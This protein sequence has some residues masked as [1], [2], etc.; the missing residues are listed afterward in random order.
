MVRIIGARR[1]TE[2]LRNMR[3]RVVDQAGTAIFVGS[4]ILETE[5]RRLIIA[6]AIQG[7]GHIPSAPGE[8]P[9]RDTG[10]LDQSV[11]AR[12]RGR[13]RSEVSANAPYALFLEFG[14]SRM[15]ERPFMRP[16]TR[17]TRRQITTLVQRA[18]R[19][20]LAR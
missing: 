11:I 13:V 14:T 17:R 9:N 19:G 2:R 5:A 1:H 6:N 7:K 10:Q 20:A 3:R 4:G 8:P 18:V 15:A 12:R 16:A